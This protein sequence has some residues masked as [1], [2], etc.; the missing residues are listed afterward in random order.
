MEFL[1][2]FLNAM[3]F[4]FTRSADSLSQRERDGVRE[5]SH[6]ISGICLQLATRFNA[7]TL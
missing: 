5:N 2:Y 1:N 3:N 7:L 4:P 6:N